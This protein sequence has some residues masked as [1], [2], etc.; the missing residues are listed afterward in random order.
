MIQ[1]PVKR[2]V[3]PFKCALLYMTFGTRAKGHLCVFA[4]PF[5]VKHFTPWFISSFKC[6]TAKK[7]SLSLQQIGR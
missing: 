7:V 3:V 6:M 2:L 1:C 5:T 4:S